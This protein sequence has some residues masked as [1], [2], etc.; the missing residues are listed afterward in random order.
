MDASF[1][2]Q[3]WA[4]NNIAF[5]NSEVNPLLVK[6]FEALALEKGD[7]IFVPLCGKTLDIAWLLS[8]G[9]RVAGAELSKVAIEQLFAELGVEPDVTEQGEM[10]RYSATDIDIFVGTI[11]ALSH[12]RLGAVDAVYD[13]AALV[14]LPG[15][16]RDRYTTHLTEIIN[17]AP[18]LLISYDCSLDKLCS[19]FSINWIPRK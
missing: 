6:H 7:R 17:K 14:A 15:E 11:F 8:K 13:R 12:E 3:K 2:H 10:T 16:M 5:H 4:D 18:Q 1:W 9:Y 19:C